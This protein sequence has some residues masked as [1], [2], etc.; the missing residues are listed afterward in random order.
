MPPVT[1]PDTLTVYPAT[2]IQ[3]GDINSGDK[4][5]LSSEILMACEQKQITYPMVRYIHVHVY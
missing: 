4:V 2:H 5:I 3:R 1:M